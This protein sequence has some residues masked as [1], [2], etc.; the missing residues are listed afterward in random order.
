[1]KDLLQ[2][3]NLVSLSRIILAPL[4]GYFL[5]KNDDRSTLICLSLLVLAGVSDGLDGYLARRLKKVS[6]LGIALD[7]VAD[8]IFA[9]LLIVFLVLFRDLPLWL[10]TVVVGRDLLILAG[11]T[12]LLK[13]KHLT[14]PSN[15]TGKYTFTVIIFLLGSYII[16]FPFGITLY[17]YLTVIMTAAS[18]IIY[19]RVFMFIRNG[20]PAPEFVDRPV[21]KTGRSLLS[22]AL[23]SIT[24]YYLYL[25]YLK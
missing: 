19:G 2:I 13:K 9:G 1:M 23:I 14:V 24:L 7:P 15:L 6:P 8:K 12:I 16:R 10:A 20:Q 11:G 5:W 4:V 3:P 21:F 18:I 22:L 25:E 17:T